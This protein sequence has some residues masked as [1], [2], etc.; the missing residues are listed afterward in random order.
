MTIKSASMTSEGLIEKVDSLKAAG[1]RVWIKAFTNDEVSYAM[2]LHSNAHSFMEAL[3]LT[4]HHMDEAPLCQGCN[5]NKVMFKN[6]NQGYKKYCTSSCMFNNA[7][8]MESQ[9]KKFGGTVNNY[10]AIRKTFE[11][12]YGGGSPLASK[13]CNDKAKATCLARYG[14]PNY[15]NVEKAKKTSLEHWGVEYYLNSEDCQRKTIQ[16][17]GVNNY[18]KTKECKEHVGKIVHDRQNIIRKK[19]S[20]TCLEKYGAKKLDAKQNRS[21]KD[22]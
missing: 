8:W 5:K 2:S 1:Y 4:Y 10:K 13:E 18:R 15:R 11:K 7:E 12:K 19:V 3:Y 22:A 21:A 9:R 20:Q 14:D 16:K 17:F 6:F